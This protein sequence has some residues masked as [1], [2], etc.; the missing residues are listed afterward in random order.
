MPHT[1]DEST[2]ALAAIL[3]VPATEGGSGVAFDDCGELG[4]ELFGQI[5]RRGLDHHAHHRLGAAG[6]HEHTTVVADAVGDDL[7]VRRRALCHRVGAARATRTL[8]STWG[9]FFIAP[10]ARSASDE[11]VRA[12]TSSTCA[13]V[14]SPSPVVASSRKMTW[15]LCSPPSA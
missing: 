9:S 2:G 13:A 5:A 3:A 8:R 1:A 6:S 7:D 15:P 14:S 4:R 11:R 12:M 10:A